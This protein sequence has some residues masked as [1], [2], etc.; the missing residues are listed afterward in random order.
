MNVLTMLK[1]AVDRALPA[2]IMCRGCLQD[3]SSDDIL[4]QF[5]QPSTGLVLVSKLSQFIV[6]RVLD[7][8][9]PGP[10]RLGDV[11]ASL[12]AA[13][14]RSRDTP[15]PLE[16]PTMRREK[17]VQSALDSFV[18]DFLVDRIVHEFKKGLDE[19]LRGKED[20]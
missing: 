16:P 19:R 10:P 8:H 18:Q 20:L 3:E 11:E 2:D 14:C 1:G 12:F 7:E 9:D 4:L 13:L 5:V 17:I 6:Q 15:A